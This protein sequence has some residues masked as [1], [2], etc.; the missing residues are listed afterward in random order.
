MNSLVEWQGDFRPDS[1]AAVVYSLWHHFL[2]DEIVDFS[3]QSEIKKSVDLQFL[4]D[5]PNF[6]AAIPYLFSKIDSQE[7][8]VES[9]LLKTLEFIQTLDPEVQSSLTWGQVHRVLFYNRII[10]ENPWLS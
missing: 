6:N 3:L 1:S 9:L 4:K 8:T 2:Q 10:D 5:T 7:K